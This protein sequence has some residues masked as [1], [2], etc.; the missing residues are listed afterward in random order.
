S[1]FLPTLLLY[2]QLRLG[3]KILNLSCKLLNNFG[4]SVAFGS[5]NPFHP[6]S[7][8]FYSCKFQ[9]LFCRGK[10]SSRIEISGII[11]TVSGMATAYKNSIR[12]KL[13]SSEYKG[14]IDA[15]CAHNPDNPDIRRILQ[16]GCASKIRPCICA[17]VAGYTQYFRFK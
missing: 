1:Y 15:A 14:R 13:K 10:P 11:M 7:P 3:A 4:K 9:N 16:S 6:E 17:P 5:G 2:L 12:T 8:L